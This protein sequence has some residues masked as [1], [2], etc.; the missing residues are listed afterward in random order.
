MIGLR[1]M[2]RKL[3][4]VT[5]IPSPYRLHLFEHLNAQA[6]QRQ[7]DMEVWFLATNERGRHWPYDP[8]LCKF[9][10]RVLP[11][12]HPRLFGQ[13]QHINPSAW[14]GVLGQSPTWLLLGGAWHFPTI[15][16]LALLGSFYRGNKSIIFHLEAN[17]HFT[18]HPRGLF[19]LLR[20]LVLKQAHAYAVPGE[21]ARTTITDYWGIAEPTFVSLPNVVD[22]EIYRLSVNR[23]HQT[24]DELRTAMDIA[25][26]DRLILF[27]AR[28]VDALK[29]NINFLK[30]FARLEHAHIHV[31]LV[32][33]GPD[34]HKIRQ[35]FNDDNRVHLLGYQEHDRM[36]E[37]FAM[38][39][40]LALP[41]FKD[42]NPLSLIE[43]LWAGLPILGSVGCGNWPETIEPG[44]N[45]W[46][47]N[48]KHPDEIYRALREFAEMTQSQLDQFGLRSLEI[49]R[50]RF[51]TEGVVSHFLDELEVLQPAR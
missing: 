51:E 19:A 47:V 17:Y 38:A 34:Y 24:R 5:N 30:E 33:D 35:L 3:L 45:G 12:I 26:L 8:S 10:H 42:P 31:F 44:K 41:S 18:S 25:P 32:G 23:A 14:W 6:D 13:E 11:G 1:H 48:P 28:L 21:I 15:A 49:A 29:G 4:I 43:G 40:L 27:P 9:P 39:D 20:K 36:I 37:L 16:G 7:I 2:P 46:L 22:E 50:E